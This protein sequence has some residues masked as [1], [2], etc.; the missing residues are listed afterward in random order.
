MDGFLCWLILGVLLIVSEFFVPGFIII[1]FGVSA[2]VVG[3]LVFLFPS[4]SLYFCNTLA[5]KRQNDA[6]CLVCQVNA[7]AHIVGGI[8]RTARIYK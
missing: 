3:G 5:Q 7:V 4:F 8:E 2:C 6:I 1:F